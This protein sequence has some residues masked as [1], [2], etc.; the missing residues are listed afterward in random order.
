MR[1]QARPDVFKNKDFLTALNL[2]LQ[3]SYSPFNLKSYGGYFVILIGIVT[4]PCQPRRVRLYVRPL[5]N[6]FSFPPQALHNH[7]LKIFGA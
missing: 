2:L 3:Y 7:I 6:T 1:H 5:L 4:V